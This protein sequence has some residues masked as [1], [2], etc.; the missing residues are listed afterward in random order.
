MAHCEWKDIS[1]LSSSSLGVPYH[2]RTAWQ[3]SESGLAI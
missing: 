2:R 1:L 3:V